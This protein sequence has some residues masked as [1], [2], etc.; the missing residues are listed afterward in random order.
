MGA[1]TPRRGPTPAPPVD[2]RRVSR[3]F[4]VVSRVLRPPIY[5]PPPS[6]YG[7]STR[8]SVQRTQ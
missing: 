6:A 3:G 8:Y 1:W 2:Y 5:L 4:S 7:Y